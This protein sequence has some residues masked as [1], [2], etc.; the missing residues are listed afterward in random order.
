MTSTPFLRALS[1]AG[2]IAFVSLGVIRIPF[3]PPATMFSTAVTWPWL[4]PSNLPA[5]DCSLAPLAAASLV[6][7]SFIF[8]KNGLLSVLVISPTWTWLAELEAPWPPQAATSSRAAKAAAIPRT[9]GDGPRPA[10]AQARR[11][12]LWTLPQVVVISNSSFPSRPAPLRGSAG[13]P[14]PSTTGQLYRPSG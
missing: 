10:A 2:M 11:D 12:D 1:S 6:A 3:T 9:L 8:T 7:P 4:S 5:P 13:E 14:T